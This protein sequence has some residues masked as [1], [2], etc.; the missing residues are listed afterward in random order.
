MN[1]QQ[2]NNAPTPT[3]VDSFAPPAQY[4][5]ASWAQNIKS[6]DDLWGQMA[7]AQSLI[8]KR[9]AGIPAD[10]ASDEE[11]NKFYQ[12]VGRPETYDK[13]SLDQ[14]DGVPAGFDL[15]PFEDKFKQMAHKAGLSSKKANEIWKD[16][17]RMELDAYGQ[18]QKESS[19]RAAAL[20]KEFEMLAQKHFGDQFDLYSGQTQDRLRAILPKDMAID[21]ENVSPAVMAAF[22]MMEKSHQSDVSA[23]NKKY[24]V[25]DALSSGGS[26]PGMNVDAVRAE[27]VKVNS[28]LQKAKIFT[29][30]YKQLE[31]TRARLRETLGRMVNK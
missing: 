30:E 21:W 27:L 20:D 25:E 16:Y 29:P 23:L 8:G 12:A 10:G 24:G 14:I 13:Y 7:N 4:A 19:E 15:S 6:N 11:W 9:P 28:S 5:S 26:V 22:I 31:E 1:D 18:G 17:M 3:T 2:S